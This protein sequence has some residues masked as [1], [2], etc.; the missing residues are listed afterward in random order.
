[1]NIPMKL[2]KTFLRLKNISYAFLEC[3]A[4][5][6]IPKSEMVKKIE[7]MGTESLFEKIPKAITIDNDYTKAMF[8]YK[9]SLC[10]Q[11]IWEIKFRANPK[12]I[13]PFSQLLYEFII[14]ELSDLKVFSDFTDPILVPIPSSRARLKEKGFNQCTLIV[15]ELK[16]I[17]DEC[18]KKN[19]DIVTN[20]LIKNR[21]TQHQ[22]AIKNRNK[23]LNNLVNSFEINKYEAKKHSLQDRCVIVIDDVITTGATMKEASRVLKKAGAKKV[24]GFALAH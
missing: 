17:D 15:K 13:S 7:K 23:R 11:A 14:D 10:R 18:D 6:L 9:N 4:N 20:L 12:I 8:S 16:K 21:D 5:I 24:I 3:I 1:M 2:R 22:V 19:F